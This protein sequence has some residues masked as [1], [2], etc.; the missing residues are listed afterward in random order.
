MAT[1]YVARLDGN[2]IGKR[3]TKDRTYT[4]AVICAQPLPTNYYHGKN[5]KYDAPH[6]S[7]W[8]GRPDLAQAQAR[9]Y[10]QL[11]ELVEIVPAE[12]A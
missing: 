10:R 2:I 1:K 12:L 5:S 4:H 3:T 9:K 11:Y 8:C 6:V 7:T